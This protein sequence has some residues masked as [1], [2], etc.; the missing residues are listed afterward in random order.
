MKKTLL[1]LFLFFVSVSAYAGLTAEQ[2]AILRPIVIAEPSL[3][4]ARD[5]GDGQMIAAW[6]NAL[7]T[8]D[9]IVTKT[10]MSRHEVL[11]D[12]SLEGTT[13]T[14]T[15]G[16][17]ITRS[18][19]ERDAFREMFNSTGSVNPTKASI[20]AAFTDIFSGAG[21]AG[22]RDHILKISKRKATR[23]EKAFSTGTGTLASPATLTW[24]GIITNDDASSLR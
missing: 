24:E 19:G 13:F 20:Q 1:G 9:F 22:N 21:G 4:Q 2:F 6:C 10:Y 3:Q 17:Y 7:A 5:V 11:V 12:T 16:A 8:P 15:A 23:A 18:Q 14:W